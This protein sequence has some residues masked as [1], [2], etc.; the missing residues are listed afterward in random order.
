MREMAETGTDIK[1]AGEAFGDLKTGADI[2]TG[3]AA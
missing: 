1:H 3:G 2:V